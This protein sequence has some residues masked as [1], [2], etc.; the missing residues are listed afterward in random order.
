MAQAS[1]AYAC[2]RI[3]A[4]SK[5][6]LD[7]ATVQRMAEGSYEDALRT[8]QDM[9]YGGGQDGDGQDAERMI[10]REMTA[11][12]RELHELSPEPDFTDLLMLEKDMLNL[13]QLLK[14]RLLG[15]GEIV[16]APGG[17]YAA[18]KLTDMVRTQDY[19][20]L[21][22]TL[23][24]ALD[25]LE[26]RMQVT[27]EPQRIS[28]AVDGAYLE[29]ALQSTKGNAFGNHYFR[30]LCDFDNVLTFLRMRAMGA[31]RDALLKALLP[32]GGIRHRD[33]AD[34]YELSADALMRFMHDS[35]CRESLLAGLNA[36]YRTGN[37]GELEKQR[38]NYLMGLVRDKKFECLTIYPIIG[39]YLAKDREAK[40]VRLIL[41]A[42]RNGLSGD[43]ILERLVTLYG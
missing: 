23:R 13:K 7:T 15:T 20:T 19:R 35:V 11:A 10:E 4:L 22:D 39:Y 32:E 38:D 16:W 2:A 31:G 26:K 9:R 18:D 33:L 5:R 8:L 6:L 43:V 42:K 27:P 34:A 14:A 3:S 24:R 30:A 41:T 12:L 37:I 17:L 21:P 29:Y 1:Y 40:A 28:I 36:M 25:R